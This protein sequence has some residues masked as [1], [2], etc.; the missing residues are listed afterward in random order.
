MT[1]LR[2][3][4]GARRSAFAACRRRYCVDDVI[5]ID[6]RGGADVQSGGEKLFG[7]TRRRG[8]R[9]ERQDAD[10]ARRTSD[11]HDGYLENYLTTGQ[12]KIIGIGR[13]VVGLRKDGSTFPM[14]LAVSEAAPGR[15]RRCSPASSATSPSASAPA[16]S[17][18][19]SEAR[20]RAILDAAVDAIITHRRARHGR[21]A[22]PGREKLFGYA[23]D[24]VIGQNVKMLMPEPY[25]DEHDGYLDNYLTTG[26]KKIIGIG[27]EVVGRAR[28]AP[29]SRWTWRSAR[30]TWADGSASSPASPATSPSASAPS[31][32]LAR[33]RGAHPGRPGRRPSTASS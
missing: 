19:D 16:G 33:Q 31:R 8:D 12:K 20:T 32:Q 14:D 28:T 29:P 26:Q 5:L 17:C 10:A 13:E 9:P 2:D 21:V 23:A 22:E 4:S 30:C 25:Q 3:G 6:A 24:E 1:I 7:Y 27:R 18:D 11:E 15:R